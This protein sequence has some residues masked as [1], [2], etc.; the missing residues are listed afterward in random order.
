M[1]TPI[2]PDEPALRAF[3]DRQRERPFSY[4]DVGATGDGTGRPDV[5]GYTH[6]HDRVR[7]GVGEAVWEQARAALSAWRMFEVRGV[8]L[9]WPDAPIRV[10]TVVAVR[11]RVAPLWTVNACRIVHLVEEPGDVERFGFAYGTL[12]G[13][14][15]DGEEVFVVEWHK[16]DDAVFWVRRAFSRPRHALV[17]LGRPWLRTIQARFA[18]ES[19]AAMKRAIAAGAPQS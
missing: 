11:A 14:A 4:S 10:G 16:Q 17:R 6:D 18:V 12:A 19:V 9:C 2:R 15:F 8:Q 3:L 5:A 13:H 7:L 1:I